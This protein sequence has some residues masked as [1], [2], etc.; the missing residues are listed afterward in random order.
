MVVR[1][2]ADRA[3]PAA[4][5]PPRH[6]RMQ[7][8]ARPRPR[9]GSWSGRRGRAR[10]AR[11]PACRNRSRASR[12]ARQRPRWR[13]IEKSR[14]G[15]GSIE[16]DGRLAASRCRRSGGMSCPS[17][18]RRAW[19]IGRATAARVVG[20]RPARR[21]ATTAAGDVKTPPACQDQTADRS[22]TTT[23]RPDAA[24]RAARTA[25]AGPPPTIAIPTRSTGSALPVTL[26]PLADPEASPRP[27]PPAASGRPR[28]RSAGRTSHGSSAPGSDRH[29]GA[30][31]WS[32]PRATSEGPRVARRSACI[33]YRSGDGRSARRRSSPGGCG[34]GRSRPPRAARHGPSRA[35]GRPPRAPTGGGS[36]VRNGRH[37][38]T[39]RRRGAIVRHRHAAPARTSLRPLPGEVSVSTPPC[40]C[41]ANG[42]GRWP[43][44]PPGL[45]G[46]AVEHR[47]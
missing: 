17:G 43:A 3:G 31:P 21:S 15:P 10:G 23:S 29:S 46:D 40:R 34:Q 44:I 19:G 45:G 22:R 18:S 13:Q 24:S 16:P 25:P 26:L 42:G 27:R 5:G 9:P 38:T 36:A 39:H 28:S 41:R 8:V 33:G 20:S 4:T 1:P 7:T 6:D 12:D 11:R 2:T 32:R 14:V 47:E 37:R 35:T 30:A